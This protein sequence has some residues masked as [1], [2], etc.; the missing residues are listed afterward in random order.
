MKRTSFEKTYDFSVKYP[1]FSAQ[2]TRGFDR[3]ATDLMVYKG[4]N[5]N[6]MNKDVVVVVLIN[7]S[8]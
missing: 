2:K 3:Y 5:G 1:T 4:L 8:Y 7:W 6:S